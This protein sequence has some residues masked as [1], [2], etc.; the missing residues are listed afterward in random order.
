[1]VDLELTRTREDRRLYRLD[2][3]GTLR[4][5]G[6]WARAAEAETTDGRWRFARRGMWRRG[7]LASDA[8]CN[9]VASFHPRDLRLPLD[10]RSGVLSSGM[11]QR[12]RWV[13]AEI[14]A[15]PVLL[16]DEPFQN[17]DAAGVAAAGAILVRRLAEGALAVV[18][19]PERR[20]LPALPGEPR[21]LRLAG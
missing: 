3:V 17:L 15:P 16:L 4:L 6:I 13:W 9:R 18:A 1:M 19:A 2:T 11:R 5:T 12:L 21:E 8:A 10:R 14:A 20:D 7:I